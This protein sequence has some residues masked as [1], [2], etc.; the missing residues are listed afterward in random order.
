[1]D[2]YRSQLYRDSVL[3]VVEA[4]QVETVGASGAASIPGVAFEPSPGHS[5]GHM[6]VVLDSGDKRALFSGDLMHHPI[7]VGNSQ[8]NSCFCEALDDARAS[9]LRILEVYAGPNTTFLTA[10]FSESSVGRVLATAN[11]FAWSFI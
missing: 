7:Q 10:H 4:G 9:R 5:L 6:C 2:P 11:G 8:W 3:P 1:V